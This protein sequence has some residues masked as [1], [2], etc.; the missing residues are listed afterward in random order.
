MPALQLSFAAYKRSGFPEAVTVNCYPEPSP[1]KPSEPF[2]LI[3]RPGLEAF[4]TVGTAPIRAI[5]QKQGLFA[6]AALVVDASG[7]STL[8]A[9]GAVTALTGATIAST[10]LV[11]VDAGLDADGNSIARIA[12][13]SALYKVTGGV[14][15]QEDFP[16][17]GGAGATSVAFYKG[18]WVASEAATDAFYYQVPATTTWV[19][20]QFA[21]A[22]YAPDK[23]VAVR[24]FG[25]LVALLGE[26][27]T[28]IWR[29]SGEVAAPL[30]PYAGLN[31][32]FGCRSR[33]AAVNCQGSLIWVDHNCAVRLCAGGAAK[34]ISDN[35]LSEQ[36]RKVASADLRATFFVKDGHPVYV[37]TLGTEATW[38]Y[39]LAA[40][41]WT[42]ANSLGY[43]YWRAHL[44]CNIGDAVLAADALSHQVWRMDPDR[45]TDGTDTF[46]VE[47]CA[48]L[49][50]LEAPVPI[51]NV[52]LHCQTG[53]APLS[54]QGSAPLV[55]LQISY[56]GGKTYGPEKTRSLGAT[57]D[58]AK[59]VRWS[60]QGTAQPPVGA[61]LKFAISDPVVRRISGVFVNTP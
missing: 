36:I 58:Y 57:G 51:A 35:G 2:A 32:D 28:E 39:D 21:S 8:D 52:E 46:T 15:T 37:L 17:V 48:F 18:Y 9:T 29:A 45:M 43:D 23:L 42:R 44:C 34:I 38:V 24:V 53:G 31:F 26:A 22:E 40:Q 30:A 33:D 54:G 1:S 56:D 7:V 10:G 14:I 61:V 3:A 4:Q 59:R 27:T 12:N 47:F 5:F 13:G 19:A 41:K 11:D 50:A 6:N 49:E 25:E 20:L 60:A 55:S 16:T